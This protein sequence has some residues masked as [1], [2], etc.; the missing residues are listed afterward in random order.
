MGVEVE[1]LNWVRGN[2]SYI[3]HVQ[4]E[5]S[6]MFILDHDRKLYE[7]VDK[8][9]D[10]TSEEIEEDLSSRLNSQIYSGKVRKPRGEDGAKRLVFVRQ[11]AGLFGFG[12]DREEEIGP[13]QTQV[14]DIKNVEVVARYRKEHI[15]ARE[16]APVAIDGASNDDS[17][18][19][20]GSLK[21]DEVL[22]ELDGAE[23]H[24][25]NLV[26]EARKN[27]Y[28][29]T[30]SLPR[31]QLP[32]VPATEY[33]AAPTP[34]MHAGRKLAQSEKSKKFTISVW[35]ADNFPLTVRQLMPFFEM[36]AM[37][38]K[39]FEK[40]QELVSMDLPPGF[41]VR[42]EIPLFAFLAAQITFLNF[43]FW[44][45]GNVPPPEMSAQGSATRWFDIPKDYQ[46]GVVIKN[47]LKEG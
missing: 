1:K 35:M 31:P 14:Y 45:D 33:F 9:R 8:T 23:S 19:I 24:V 37:G 6:K 44:K 29:F 38:N 22:Q 41:P 34:Y 12:G 17:Q 39:N 4:D 16:A 40:V 26:N 13:Y 36:M 46:K 18:S 15:Q 27:L 2:I 21:S 25:Q 20:N 43:S 28:S 5:E 11:Q 32:T 3:F 7:E 30:P 42:I 47:I 10:F